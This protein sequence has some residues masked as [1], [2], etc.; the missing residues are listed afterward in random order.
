MVFGAIAM[1]V[2]ALQKIQNPSEVQSDLMIL[3]ALF[4][5]AVNGLAVLKI[6]SGKTMNEKVISLHLL[7]DLLGVDS[8]VSGS[9]CNLY[10]RLAYT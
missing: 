6:K 1:F 5:V 8:R 10:Y 4:G 3:F 9:Y 2:L 7:E